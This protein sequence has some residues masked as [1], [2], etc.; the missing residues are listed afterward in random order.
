MPCPRF[1]ST[2]QRP[3]TVVPYQTQLPA[4]FGRQVSDTIRIAPS[5]FQCIA[6]HLCNM[7]QCNKRAR[8]RCIVWKVV[9]GY[10]GADVSRQTPCG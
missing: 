3:D 9:S 4:S 1:Y 7:Q 10:C 5:E 2:K 8:L 6:H